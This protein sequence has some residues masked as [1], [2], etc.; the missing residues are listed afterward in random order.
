[1]RK[2]AGGENEG[3]RPRPPG[4]LQKAHSVHSSLFGMRPIAAPV[5]LESLPAP[6]VRYWFLSH[7]AAGPESQRCDRGKYPLK[8]FTAQNTGPQAAV[9]DIDAV[10]RRLA[11]A[12]LRRPDGRV[13]RV[14]PVGKRPARRRPKVE[15]VRRG[16]VAREEV[17]IDVVSLALQR[18][19]NRLDVGLNGS[20]RCRWDPL[21]SCTQHKRRNRALT[22]FRGRARQERLRESFASVHRRV[23]EPDERAYH[24]RASVHKDGH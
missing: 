21:V 14:A 23:T 10:Q 20:M 24:S 22:D 18:E 17:V 5:S 12:V 9:L 11:H 6:K 7:G 13:P 15:D 8:R 3:M 19:L 4:S 16:R 2:R 1:M